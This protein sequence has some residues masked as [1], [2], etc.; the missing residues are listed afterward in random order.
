LDAMTRMIAPILVY[1]SDEI[2]QYMPH[3]DKDNKE[4]VVFNDMPSKTGVA[5]DEEFIAIWDRIHETRDVVKKALEV[6]IK[7][8]TLR[9]SLEAK[10]ILT[11]GGQQYD[12]LKKAENELA[13]AFIVSQ[14]AIVNADTDEM[15]VEVKHADGEKCERCWSFSDT[16]GQNTD[17][18]TLCARCA[19]VIEAGDFTDILN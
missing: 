16:V 9:S 3:K 8:K 19:A 12:F 1:T 14:V 10:I 2:W 17:H 4:N 15:K 18:P 13:G 7:E 5:L 6:K 11:A